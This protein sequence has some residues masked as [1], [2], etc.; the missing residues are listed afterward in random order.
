MPV[1]I[2]SLSKRRELKF[3]SRVPLNKLRSVE[4]FNLAWGVVGIFV[5]FP[6]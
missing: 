1:N 2:Q 5:I 6:A 3:Q 4:P